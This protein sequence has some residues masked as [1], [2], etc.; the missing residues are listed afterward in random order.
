MTLN[1]KQYKITVEIQVEG[2]WEKVDPLKL[3]NVLNQ[4]GV[5]GGKTSLEQLAKRCYKI[6]G[7]TGPVSASSFTV[8]LG[9]K[10][11]PWSL[12]GATLGRIADRFKDAPPGVAVIKIEYKTDDSSKVQTIEFKDFTLPPETIQKLNKQTGKI[13]ELTNAIFAQRHQLVSKKALPALESRASTDTKKLEAIER[14]LNVTNNSGEGNKCAAI[15]VAMILLQRYGDLQTAKAAILSM[16]EGLQLPAE[17]GRDAQDI[18]TNLLIDLAASLIE[19]RPEFSN[20]D[21]ADSSNPYYANI[22]ASLSLR[23]A[24]RPQPASNADRKMVAKEYADLIRSNGEMLDV[25]FFDALNLLGIPSITL[26]PSTT[27]FVLGSIY[28]QNLFKADIDHI[29]GSDLGQ[30]CFVV[31]DQ[32]HYRAAMLP[33]NLTA[34]QTSALRSILRNDMTKLLQELDKEIPT[35][36]PGRSNFVENRN[37]IYPKIAYLMA[38]YPTDAK[39]RIIAL[40]TKEKRIFDVETLNRANGD[41]F[42]QGALLAFLRPNMNEEIQRL[43]GLV[44]AVVPS[45]SAGDI[46]SNPSYNAIN[47]IITDLIRHYPN[48]T[49]PLIIE[50]LNANRRNF[51]PNLSTLAGDAFIQEAVRA[52][53][54][55]P[56]TDVEGVD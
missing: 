16:N 6:Y 21:A 24:G 28:S 3:R 55:A 56:K 25:S 51:N 19:N 54:T 30:I 31:H 26:K 46:R 17:R 15:S 39:P 44:K 23:A 1:G 52:F 38:R 48:E 53:L 27:G 8:Y 13:A 12:K 5:P 37:K 4:L 36:Q 11:A 22:V 33:T 35:L 18:L 20:A 2:K 7:A 45:P 50:K 49:K 9:Q 10:E 42:I 40:L 14:V 43:D 41:A 47:T 34:E 32:L 29:E